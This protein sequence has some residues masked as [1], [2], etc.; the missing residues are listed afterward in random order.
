MTLADKIL[1]LRKAR[2]I[3]QDELAE[4]L[5]VSRQAVSRWETGTAMPDAMNILQLSRLF[6]VTTDYLL[7]DS[8][9]S[10]N[11]LPPVK[12]ARA[13]S[14]EQLTIMTI[15]LEGMAAILQFTAMIILQSSL[16]TLLS[17][18]LIPLVIGG[19]EYSRRKYGTNR[20]A[21]HL[22]RH[23]Y[24]ITAWLGPYFPIRFI[25]IS[26][27]AFYPRPYSSPVMELIVLMVYVS[28]AL[29]ICRW[30]NRRYTPEE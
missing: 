25:V 4:A 20:H 1:A 30:A 16:F 23:F 24:R 7:N 8:Y 11:D 6:Q 9:S 5:N 17:F 29:L 21:A 2:G 14:V 10:D 18:T 12:G 27:F 19:F 13:D 15:T 22:C 26:M 3:S 28:A